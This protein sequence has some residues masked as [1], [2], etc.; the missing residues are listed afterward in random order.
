MAKIQQI[1]LPI[2][3]TANNLLLRVLPFDMEAK[4]ASF[5]YELQNITE[6]QFGNDI[7]I[8]HS[9]NAEMTESEYALWGSDN[10]YCLQWIANKLGI[11]L[12]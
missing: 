12:I 6:T 11:T 8:I 7:K 4:T 3:G 10:S 9:G 1:T 2:L 5:Y